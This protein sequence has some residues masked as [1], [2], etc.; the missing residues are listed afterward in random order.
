MNLQ[1]MF[2]EVQKAC[3]KFAKFVRP[4]NKE[5]EKFYAGLAEDEETVT[6]LKIW[7]VG[8]VTKS[9]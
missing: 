6:E 4:T 5:V 9:S 2:R 8:R 1:R 3:K 7:P